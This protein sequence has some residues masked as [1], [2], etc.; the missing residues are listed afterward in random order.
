MSQYARMFDNL[1]SIADEANERILPLINGENT[2]FTFT[3]PEI[4][5]KSVSEHLKWWGN[6]IKE[7]ENN[8]VP[9]VDSTCTKMVHMKLDADVLL[10]GLANPKEA[11]LMADRYYGGMDDMVRSMLLD[12]WATMTDMEASM[13]NVGRF[14]N[15]VDVALMTETQF[16]NTYAES[17]AVGIFEQIENIFETDATG[18]E[19]DYEGYT[20][21]TTEDGDKLLDV[22]KTIN[23]NIHN[24][25]NLRKQFYEEFG[26]TNDYDSIDI[27][28]RSSENPI[29]NHLIIEYSVYKSNEDSSVSG[30]D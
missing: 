11:H 28:V 26:L 2:T 10:E 16:D 30:S 9:D 4:P 21:A 3:E 7:K 13:E 12:H 25:V 24:R 14:S 29:D 6:V 20:K 22:M 8:P 5:Q 27:D 15:D 19:F 1:A 17:M 18:E 23:G